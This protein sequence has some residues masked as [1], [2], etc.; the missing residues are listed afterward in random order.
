MSGAVVI[1]TNSV[2]GGGLVRRCFPELH[3]AQPWAD[4]V[5]KLQA[6]LWPLM[7]YGHC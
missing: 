6:A 1:A 3:A 2:Q 5:G 4:F 7:H